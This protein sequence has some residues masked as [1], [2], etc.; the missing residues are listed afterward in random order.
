LLVLLALSVFACWLFARGGIVSDPAGSFPFDAAQPFKLDFG[1]GS[2]M[3]GLDTV[4]IAEDGRASCYRSLH[5]GRWEKASM[6][7]SQEY[8]TAI[9][10]AVTHC[11]LPRLEKAYYPIPGRIDG[12]QWVFW[13]RQGERQ[14]A[15]YFDNSFPASIR[16]FADEL[17]RTLHFAGY[18]A[19]DWHPASRN[20]AALWKS[21]K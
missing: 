14:K 5:D 13:L 1:R 8:V 20:D 16:N 7:L 11:G 6:R 21:I 17:D 19:L 4:S 3:H 18:D 2:G 12:T 9:A 15:T 10:Q